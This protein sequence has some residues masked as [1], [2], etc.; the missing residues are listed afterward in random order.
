MLIKH[1]AELSTLL[2]SRPHAEC[3]I[4]HIRSMSKAINA[5]ISSELFIKFV[6]R[7]DKNVLTGS[8]KLNGDSHH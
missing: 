5:R 2:T 6:N 4:L 1:E 8:L 3:F 7:F